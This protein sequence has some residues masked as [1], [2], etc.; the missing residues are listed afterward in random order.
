MLHEAGPRSPSMLHCSHR[1]TRMQGR[2][3]SGRARRAPIRITGSYGAFTQR[4]C[5][6]AE[7]DVECGWRVVAVIGCGHPPLG[8]MAIDRRALRRRGRALSDANAHWPPRAGRAGP[9]E[10]CPVG[11]AE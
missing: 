7:W 4:A 1:R 11:N 3:P 10:E 9:G 5:G 8:S 6:P 2:D